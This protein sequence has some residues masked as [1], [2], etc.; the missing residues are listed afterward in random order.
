MNARRTQKI[1]QTTHAGKHQPHTAKRFAHQ[2]ES[3]GPSIVRLPGNMF[4]T[5]NNKHDVRFVY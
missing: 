2:K 4:P 5:L 1:D 3:N